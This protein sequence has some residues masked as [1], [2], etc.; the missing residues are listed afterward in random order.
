MEDIY[1]NP[2]ELV[3]SL[4]GSILPIIMFLASAYYLS[5]KTNTITIL[6]AIGTFIG[7]LSSISFT[8]IP[9]FIDSDFYGSSIFSAIQSISFLGRAAFVVGFV[10]LIMK[11]VKRIDY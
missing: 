6:L 4:T 2:V 1:Y 7:L 8:I 3:F 5:K 9:R 10:M 11:E